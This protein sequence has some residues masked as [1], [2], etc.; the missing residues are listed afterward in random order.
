MNPF[1]AVISYSVCLISHR[2]YISQG[3]ADITFQLPGFLGTK[4]ISGNSFMTPVTFAGCNGLPDIQFLSVISVDSAPTA[5]TV[6]MD[7]IVPNPGQVLFILGDI[8]LHMFSKEGVEV[9][10]IVFQNMTLQH[11]E[12]KITAVAT[13]TAENS[14]TIDARLRVEDDVLMLAGFKGSSRNSI[15]AEVW[16]TFETQVTIPATMFSK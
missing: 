2:D 1:G 12:N 11:G 5:V 7:S 15:L 3:T 13:F 16:S 10:S 4:V 14:K 9:G 8:V 6:T